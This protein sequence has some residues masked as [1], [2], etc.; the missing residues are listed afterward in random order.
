MEIFERILGI[1]LPV[2]IIIALGYGYAR[3]RGEAVRSDITPVN[4]IS[5]EVLC[6]LLVFT[7][8]AAKDFDLA[9]NGMLILAGV[10]ISLGSGLLAWPVARLFGYDVRS[11]VPPMIYNN[12]GNMGLP[13]AILAFGADSLGSA[14]ALFMACNLMYFSVGIKIIESGRSKA[15]GVRISPWKFLANPM[16]IA[17]FVGM[18]FAIVHVP[19]PAPLFIALKMMGDACIPLMLFALGV[20]MMD[21]SLKSWH[22]GLVGAI[23]CPAAGLIVAWVLDH[24]ISLSPEQR[25]Q[26]FLFAS[27]PPA[28]FCFMVAEQYKQEPEKVA[29]IVLLGN[30]A[31]FVFVPVGLWMGLPN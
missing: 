8:L 27:L 16:M 24:A 4:R 15:N 3:L 1:I 9:N 25:G 30:L 2:F 28:V 20:R 22:I 11:F 23:V 17:M 26:M 5:M 29:S 14:V 13:L 6:P 7:A 18:V 12:C 21:V 19:L 10:L 31:A